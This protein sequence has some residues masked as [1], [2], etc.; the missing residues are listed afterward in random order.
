MK[1]LFLADV[2]S[3]HTQKWAGALA[4]KGIEIIIFSIN[5]NTSDWL[6]KFPSIIL[7]DGSAVSRKIIQNGSLKKIYYLKAVP[8][9]KRVIKKYKPDIVHAHYASSYG[10][11]GAFSGFH[12][13]IISVWGSDVLTFPVGKIINKYILKFNFRNAD[14]ILAT[15]DFLLNETKKYTNKIV[16]KIPF[17]VDLNYFKFKKVERIFTSDTIVIGTIKSLE[18]IYGI[19]ILINAFKRVFDENKFGSVKLLIV[20]SGNLESEY[21]LLVEELNLHDHVVFAGK[22]SYEQV[23]DYHN[24]IDIFVNVSR[25]ESFGVSVLEAS[26][27]EKPVIVSNAG[28]LGEVV[29][30]NLTG[31]IVETEN[32]DDTAS[33]LKVL[34]SNERMRKEMGIQGRNFVKEHY[35]FTSNLTDTLSIYTELIKK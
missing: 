26:A 9:L 6:Q 13:Y 10:L 12:P 33:A 31:L 16:K 25:S 27:C 15:S 23:V 28:G 35:E 3:P 14:I 11:I 4:S 30:N 24:M 1:I 20:G 7:I 32:V 18:H 2:N 8:L 17:G 21:R 22:I 19:D 34:I 5:K 29:V